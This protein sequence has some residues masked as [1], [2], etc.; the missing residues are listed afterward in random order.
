[1]YRIKSFINNSKPNG[2]T[3]LVT[4]FSRLFKQGFTKQA[5]RDAPKPTDISILMRNW[6]DNDIILPSGLAV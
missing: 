3:P 2:K 6:A 1:L 5:F 4:D